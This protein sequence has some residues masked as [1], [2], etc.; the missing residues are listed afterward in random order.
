MVAQLEVNEHVV[1]GLKRAETLAFPIL[2]ALAFL[3]FRSLVAALLPL[4]V[5]ALAIVATM[6]VL[7]VATM[8]TSISIFA[9]NLVTGLGLGL[10]DR[11]QPLHRLPL[12]RGD[13]A[14]RTRG[15]GDAAHPGHRRPHGRCS[16]R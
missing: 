14:Q 7:T 5:G 12:P 6:F 2:L 16:A 1:S 10:G 15:G 8:L 4:M 13:R 3:F 11:L 9:M